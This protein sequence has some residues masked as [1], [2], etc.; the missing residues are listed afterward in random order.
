MKLIGRKVVNGSVDMDGKH[1]VILTFSDELT[2][3]AVA[4]YF[5][6]LKWAATILCAVDYMLLNTGV[7][8]IGEHIGSLRYHFNNYKRELTN[9]TKERDD[10]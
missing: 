2:D 7:E 9:L 5:C 8:S 10:D 3:K 1:P 4:E 6:M